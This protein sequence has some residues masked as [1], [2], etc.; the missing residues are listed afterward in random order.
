MAPSNF[1]QYID[2]KAFDDM[3]TTRFS[4][5]TRTRNTERKQSARDNNLKNLCINSIGMLA[6]NSNI[7]RSAM[8]NYHK[9]YDSYRGYSG[10]S[11]DSKKVIV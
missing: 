4:E 2:Q 8:M 3:N 5:T 7:S 10:K 9:V 6:L 1:G 11:R